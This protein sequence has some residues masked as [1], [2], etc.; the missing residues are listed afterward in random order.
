MNREAQ[1]LKELG[2][3][4]AEPMRKQP[5]KPFELKVGEDE[6]C[7]SQFK[8]YFRPVPGDIGVSMTQGTINFKVSHGFFITLLIRFCPF[9]G[10][11]F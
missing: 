6:V 11:K 7:C 8:E 4:E 5:L 1:I 10:K 2:Y 3:D 9:C